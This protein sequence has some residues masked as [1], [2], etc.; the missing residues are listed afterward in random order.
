MTPQEH[1]KK[2]L[3]EWFLCSK[4]RPKS[5]AVDIQLDKDVLE[6]WA[7]YLDRQLAWSNDDDKLQ[8]VCYQFESRLNALK[9][10]II[11]EVLKNGSV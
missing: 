11:I 6:P 4:A 5:Q 10:K 8:E 9:E 7:A 1:A 2:L 3:N